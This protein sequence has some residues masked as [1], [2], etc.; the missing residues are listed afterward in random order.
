MWNKANYIQAH[1][2]TATA[3]GKGA[4]VAWMLQEWS[5]DISCRAKLQV[6]PAFFF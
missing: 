3:A 4:T 5:S 6:L 1:L 2:S